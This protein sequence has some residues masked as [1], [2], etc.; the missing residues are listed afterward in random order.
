MT[1]HFIVIINIL[2]NNQNNIKNIW[3]EVEYQ[4]TYM[5]KLDYNATVIKNFKVNLRIA[6][7]S[8]KGLTKLSRN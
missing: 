4:V 5:V 3:T 7:H 1:K 2:Q 6:G 8:P